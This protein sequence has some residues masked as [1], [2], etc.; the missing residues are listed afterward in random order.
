[1]IVEITGSN[2][3]DAAKVEMKENEIFT[4]FFYY[5]YFTKV[6]KLPENRG[7]GACPLPYFRAFISHFVI[8]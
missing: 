1:M 6:E 5:Q 7:A 4:R 2:P 8:Y 3:V